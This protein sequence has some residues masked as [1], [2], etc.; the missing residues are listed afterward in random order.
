MK[1]SLEGTMPALPPLIADRRV[2]AARS[3]GW[4]MGDHPDLSRRRKIVARYAVATLSMGL[5][6]LYQTGMVRRVPE[7]P[8]DRFDANRIEASAQGYQV[9]GVPDAVLAVFNNASTMLLATLG[10]PGARPR[11]LRALLAAKVTV[12]SAYVA[13]LAVD[14]ATQHKLLCTYCLVASAATWGALAPAWRQAG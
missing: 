4:R 12:D 13:K 11:A 1:P 2:A 8:F 5:A 7:L 14:Q 10:G 9:L 3:V 6:S